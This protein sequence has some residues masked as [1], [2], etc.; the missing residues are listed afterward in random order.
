MS[1]AIPGRGGGL[2]TPRRLPRGGPVTVDWQ[3]PLARGLLACY[4]PGLAVGANIAGLGGDLTLEANASLR[5]GLEGPG[6]ASTQANSGAMGLAPASFKGLSAYS[7]YFRAQVLGNSSGSCD[8]M[9]IAYDNAG[10]SP[11]D[12][13]GI[14][15]HSGGTIMGASRIVWGTSSGAASADSRFTTPAVGDVV[16]WGA[17]GFVPSGT[18]QAYVNGVATGSSA[19]TAAAS[20]FSNSATSTVCLNTYPTGSRFSNTITFMGCIWDRL[21]TADE[22][23]MLHQ[24]PYDLLITGN[25]DLAALDVVAPPPGSGG[26]GAG[27]ITGRKLNRMRLVA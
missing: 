6:L 7:M 14:S 8:L 9:A 23:M 24:A 4:V 26:V 19:S 27:L 12:T 15:A 22:W 17:T 5:G 11:F 1:L 3:S 16:S 21:L 13:F 20:P 10:T 2:M 25:D 18:V